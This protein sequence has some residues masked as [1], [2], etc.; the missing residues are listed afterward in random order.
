MSNGVKSVISVLNSTNV[1]PQLRTGRSA[2][3]NAAR[4]GADCCR[5]ILA[6]DVVGYSR[7]MAADETGTLAQFKTH[8]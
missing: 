1:S 7:L 3:S 8:R 4:H 5:G 6:A 2:K